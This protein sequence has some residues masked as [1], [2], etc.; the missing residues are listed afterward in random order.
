[1]VNIAQV[2]ELRDKTG[3][4]IM[5]AK[6][7]LEEADGNLDAALKILSEKGLATASKRSGRSTSEGRVISYIHT[8]GRIG[9]ML[10][11]KCET[12]FVGKTQ[13]FTD[14][15]KNIAAM[16]PFY[17]DRDSIPDDITDF[18]DHEILMEQEYI[19]DSSI[20][21]RDLVNATISKTGENIRVTRFVRYELGD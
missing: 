19:R 10:E 8:G 7:A 4:G 11:I 12:D 16:N 9:A 21:I 2:K 20:T 3:V 17:V 13:E 15:W 14:L 6:N 5:D 18:E 1:M